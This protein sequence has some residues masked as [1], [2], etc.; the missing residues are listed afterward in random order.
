MSEVAEDAPVHEGL[1]ASLVRLARPF[2]L[3]PPVVGILSGAVCALGVAGDTHVRLA[4]VLVASACAGALNAASNALNQLTDL[5]ADR[6][7]KP[8]RPLVTGALSTEQARAFVVAAYVIALVPTL[9]LGW[10]VFA[11]F[12]AA[13]VATLVYSV[14]AL[15]R[16]KARG[17]LANLTIAVPRGLLLKVAGWATVASIASADPWVVGSVFACFLLGAASTKDFADIDGDL[18]DGCRTLPIVYGPKRAAQIMA[19]FL[20]LPW[21]WLA[22]AAWLPDPTHPGEP[23]LSADPVALT[24]VA[25]GTGLWGSWTARALLSDPD[26]LTRTENHPAWRSMYGM[27]LLAQTGLAIAYL[28]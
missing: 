3:L 27:M 8:D 4:P 13:A 6:W 28:V 2:T 7:N 11:C 19:P 14:P 16:L 25:V 18:R 22:I 21:L 23:L 24:L 1:V 26:A 20:V 5:E 12:L 9:W 17:F 15:G 10:P